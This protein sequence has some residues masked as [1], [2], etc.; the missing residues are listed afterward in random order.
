M[1]REPGPSRDNTRS[2][3]VRGSQRPV[4]P[5][6]LSR[7]TLQPLL[8]SRATRVWVRVMRAGDAAGNGCMGDQCTDHGNTIVSPMLPVGVAWE[9]FMS[10]SALLGQLDDLRMLPPPSPTAPQRPLR[11][12]RRQ[13]A[14][15][16]LR[17]LAR[18]ILDRLVHTQDQASGLDRRLDGIYLD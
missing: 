14:L 18:F 12:P 7:C 1:L 3:G 8:N 17:L 4:Q 16:G 15:R 10:I 13:T 5:D 11:S 6:L 2:S 9:L